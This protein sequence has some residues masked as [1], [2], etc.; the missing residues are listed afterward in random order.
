MLNRPAPSLVS[1]CLS[2]TYHF[3]NTSAFLSVLPT[4]HSLHIISSIIF[5]L[6]STRHS[7]IPITL[8]TWLPNPSLARNPSC[9][10]QHRS[11]SFLYLSL[12]LCFFASRIQPE[13]QMGV[14]GSS[15]IFLAS[16]LLIYHYIG[17]LAFTLPFLLTCLF[18]NV[19]QTRGNIRPVF[20]RHRLTMDIKP[21][22]YYL[23]FTLNFFFRVRIL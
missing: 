4:S 22:D 2:P 1:D 8:C 13:F 17:V 16:C 18:Q 12:L 20:T 7:S 23:S 3:V 5:L 15:L 9:T 19:N 11:L 10:S 14:V 21:G 6:C